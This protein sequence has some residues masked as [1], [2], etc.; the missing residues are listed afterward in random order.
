MN[1]SPA[2][3]LG[4]IKELKDGK[5]HLV[6][7]RYILVLCCEDNTHYVSLLVKGDETRQAVFYIMDELDQID[8]TVS[9]KFPSCTVINTCM[10]ERLDDDSGT[11]HQVRLHQAC[12]EA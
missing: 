3:E 1:V 12:H 8:K 4:H 10:L 5:Y 9:Q 6:E 11:W 2:D 7:L